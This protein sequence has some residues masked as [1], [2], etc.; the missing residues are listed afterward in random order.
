MTLIYFV[1]LKQ[2]SQ[3]VTVWNTPISHYEHSIDF[4]PIFFTS[5]IMLTNRL[6]SEKWGERLPI[7][8]CFF[9]YLRP[10]L[11]NFCLQPKR[12]SCIIVDNDETPSVNIHATALLAQSICSSAPWLKEFLRF[13]KS[14]KKIR[15]KRDCQI[16][17]VNI[18][19]V[20]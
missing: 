19:W 6:G 4:S 16:T 1:S 2:I 17:S 14:F 7:S 15:S 18:S 12:R 9:F 5:L 3:I 10:F 8:S 11:R 13:K 20:Q